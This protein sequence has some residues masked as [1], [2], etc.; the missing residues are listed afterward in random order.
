MKKKQQ[1]SKRSLYKRI[2]YLAVPLL[3]LAV[4]I[5]LLLQL[6]KQSPAY[7][8][9]IIEDLQE[10]EAQMLQGLLEQKPY[11]SEVWYMT[12]EQ[13]LEQERERLGVDPVELAGMNPYLPLVDLRL[14]TEY[15]VPDSFPWIEADLLSVP[16]V[17]EVTPP[18]NFQNLPEDMKN[19][20]RNKLIL[21]VIIFVLSLLTLR[22]A[23]RMKNIKVGSI[24]SHK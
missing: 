3:P 7:I 19:L 18:E 10:D 6:N 17:T 21:L 1:T 9:S 4:C 11:V 20:R 22:R 15:A 12:K 2:V 14:K 5:V 16:T 13:V 23:F 8:L 24:N